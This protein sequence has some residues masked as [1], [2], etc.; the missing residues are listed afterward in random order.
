MKEISGKMIRMSEK[1]FGYFESMLPGDSRELI[2]V[3][4]TE[5]KKRK[6]RLDLEKKL[7]KIEEEIKNAQ[8]S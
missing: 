6:P 4:K 7:N 8:S 3:H 1:F 5:V 2:E